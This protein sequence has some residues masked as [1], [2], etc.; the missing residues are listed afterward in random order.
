MFTGPPP[1][2]P[3]KALAEIQS[4]ITELEAHN[5]RYYVLAQ[6]TI[7]DSEYDRLMQRLI[8]LEK[9]F[10]E[11]V[12]PY[13]PSQKVGG[14]LTKEFPVFYHRRPML[15]LENAYSWGE[16]LQWLERL[17]RLTLEAL[18]PYVAQLK[19]DGVALSLHYEQGILVRGV[20]R[21]DG[22][23]GDDIT[24]NVKTLRG[25][26]LR[27]R[28]DPPPPY[29]EVR[30]EAIMWRE[31]F[32]QLN[33]Q[34]E[35]IGAP[36]F[37][38]PRN[39]TA[40]SL[41]LQ[42]AQEV[43]RRKIRF[44]AYYM[45]AEGFS[46]PDSDYARVRILHQ[47]GF[48]TGQADAQITDL[49]ALKSYLISWEKKREALP[50]DTDGVV[51]KIDSHALR[52]V[53]GSTA[54]SP[55]WAIAYKYQPAQAITQVIS[56][57]FQ[58]G[59]TGYITPVANLAGVHLSGT[60]VKRASLYNY[61]ELDRLDLHLGDWV[62]VE[63]SG[64]IIPKIVRVL[65]E[66]RPADA[67]PVE[68]PAA[69]PVCGTPLEKEA[70]GVGRYCPNREGCF[71]QIVGKIAHFATR[72]AMDIQGLGEE[73][74]TKLVQAGVRNF[75]DLYEL[76]LEK[77]LE[78]PGFAKKSASNLLQ[79]IE[80]SKKRPLERFIYALGIRYVG[81]TVAEKLARTFGSLEAL[82][83]ASEE[84]LAAIYEIGPQ[85]A[86]SVY[87][88]FQDPAHRAEIKK[89][90]DL[91][92]TFEVSEAVSEGALCGLRIL[93]TG[94]IEG[95]TRQQ[96]KSYIVAHGGIYASGVSKNLDYLVVGQEASAAKLEKAK[97]LGVKILTP[98]ELEA[99]VGTPL[100]AD[101]KT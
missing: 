45:E 26:P 46:L 2:D 84:K 89:L 91:G 66:R 94:T 71:P 79:A 98:S 101:K 59:R 72:K 49:E 86:R 12:F 38:N 1:T 19:L 11:Y 13:S 43:A 93:V 60:L 31:D 9:A 52:E 40:G 29:V 54:K 50:Y 16:I 82:M 80:A 88:Y 8:A 20:T 7:S 6:P 14:T 62:V 24:P 48:I 28:V 81:E 4:L 64:E 15:S 30:G 87:A 61:D 77:L 97:Q 75:S 69:C 33:R 18:A 83:D 92:L 74:A 5:Y 56:V 36:T 63:K 68:R 55:R 70:E 44:V 51:I 67:P 58:V 53:L 42:D 47:W 65:V 96:V 57:D 17:K 90:L 32:M 35:E 21:G 27:L 73:V 22:E 41:K 3:E 78:L 76:T 34:R 85:I 23:K 39:A 99:M 10:P 100:R 25:V 37:M 95:L